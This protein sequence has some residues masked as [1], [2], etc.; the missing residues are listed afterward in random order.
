MA[1]K[2]IVSV[3]NDLSFDQRVD[4][5]CTTLHEMGLEV[6]LVGR[7]LPESKTIE[8]DYKTKR[9]KLLFTKGALFYAFF[10][11]RLFFLL[12][13]SKVDIYHSNDLDTL[14]ANYLAAR[15][16]GKQLVY[17]S[18]EYFL[19]VPEI[20]GRAVKKVWTAIERFIFPKLKTIITVNPSIAQLYE[21]D[22]GKKLIVV[23]NLPIVQEIKKV[24]TKEDLGIPLDKSILILQGAGINIDRGAEELLEAIALSNNYVLY[25]VGTGD[26]LSKLK[27][28][29]LI[30]DLK[31]KVVFIGR[32]PYQ[33]MMQYTLNADVGVTLDK[34]TNINYRFSLPNKIFDYMKAGIPVLASNLKEVANIINTYKVGLVIENH[35]P[36]T[37]LYGLD[38]ILASKELLQEYSQ[39][40]LKAIEEL[41]WE[42]E[43]EP[44]KEIYSTFKYNN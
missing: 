34:D 17:D 20:Q 16:R 40:G 11:L 15:I 33:E 25:I 24:K 9:I 7:F 41:N 5:M 39:N 23:R 13:F 27:K 37:I 26:V 44:V 28:R 10:N 19:G 1:K 30:K 4:K 38:S 35:E 29:A 31:D 43:V 2:V 42:K 22:Y 36:K 21:E 14:L 18:H 12:L 3:T 6:K 8:R 32:L